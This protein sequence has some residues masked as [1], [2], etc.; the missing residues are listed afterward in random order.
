MTT[1]VDVYSQTN[2]AFLGVVLHEFAVGYQKAAEE[3]RDGSVYF[4]A[5]NDINCGVVTETRSYSMRD[6]GSDEN[7]LSLHV[8]VLCS[9][10]RHFAANKSPV[11]GVIVFDQISRPYYP[12]EE[13]PEEANVP[14]S[15]DTKACLLYTSPSTRD[16]G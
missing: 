13:N 4:R 12:P 2:P 3:Y 11:P 1:S 7:Y 14:L 5:I 16:R 8:S 15:E 10:H 6:V 9:L